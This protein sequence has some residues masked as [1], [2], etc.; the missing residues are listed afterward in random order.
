LI[1]IHPVS[2]W[3]S[4][5]FFWDRSFLSHQPSEGGTSNCRPV[6]QTTRAFCITAKLGGRGSLW[7]IRDGVDLVASPALCAMPRKQ[8]CWRR[9]RWGRCA[10]Q[11]SR[12]FS[13]DTPL[14]FVTDPDTSDESSRSRKGRAAEANRSAGRGRFPRVDLHSAPGRLLGIMSPGTMTGVGGASL[15][16]DRRRRVTPA[17]TASQETWPEAEPKAMTSPF[18]ES[19][20]GTPT[21]ERIR[22]GASRA[23]WRG[24]Y[25]S[26]FVGVPLPFFSSWLGYGETAVANRDTEAPPLVVLF[27]PVLALPPTRSALRR[28]RTLRSSQSERRRVT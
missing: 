14:T 18:G 28:T 27:H 6:Y 7:V 20:G 3:K 25:G 24:G 19:R 23:R 10:G 5:E 1:A 13:C 15:G 11:K 8:K 26:A 22:K 4:L 9:P 12:H 16:W 17:Q 21:G 2:F